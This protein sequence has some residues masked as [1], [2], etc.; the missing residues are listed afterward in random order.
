LLEKAVKE[1]K[2]KVDELVRV[3]FISFLDLSEELISTQDG[4]L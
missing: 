2:A 4:E 1:I 3:F